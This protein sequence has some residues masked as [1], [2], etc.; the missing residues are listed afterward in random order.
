M[1]G[2]GFSFIPSFLL[3]PHPLTLTL[4]V[5]FAFCLAFL[6]WLLSSSFQALTDTRTLAA[7]PPPQAWQPFPRRLP[8][9]MDGQGRAG[10]Q[11]RTGGRGTD[12]QEEECSTAVRPC[13]AL[14]PAPAPPSSLPSLPQ[15]H[16]HPHCL[17]LHTFPLYTALY[18]PFSL[19]MHLWWLLVSLP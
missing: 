10:R 17:C 16:P 12:R 3:P 9:G 19:C 6:A 7:L 2:K 15:P 5:L 14:P 8:H 4:H 11:D 13:A 18:L 1:A